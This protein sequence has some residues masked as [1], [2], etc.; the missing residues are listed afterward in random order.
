M[1]VYPAPTPT[2]KP[3]YESRTIWAAGAVLLLTVVWTILT[4]AEV[5]VPAWLAQG[6]A[7]LWGI[8]VAALRLSTSQPIGGSSPPT[9]DGPL[10]P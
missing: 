5:E 8:V 7:A 9:G 2:P 3:W 1:T 10:S 6:V 4:L